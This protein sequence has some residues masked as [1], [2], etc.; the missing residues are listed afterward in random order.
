M[1]F[2]FDESPD[3]LLGHRTLALL[4]IKTKQV[5]KKDYKMK[6]RELDS[7]EEVERD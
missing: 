5:M 2:N 6:G 1:S 4:D 7:M 3:E